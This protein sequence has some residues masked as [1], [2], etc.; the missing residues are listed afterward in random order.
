MT[1]SL[2]A[3]F[4]MLYA[5]SLCTWQGHKLFLWTEAF[6]SAMEMIPSCID[7]LSRWHIWF[8]YTYLLYFRVFRSQQFCSKGTIAASHGHY[9]FSYFLAVVLWLNFCNLTQMR[10]RSSRE[11]CGL[12]GIIA[13]KDLV[14]TIMY[15][16]KKTITKISLW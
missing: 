14:F 12:Q 1:I 10:I 8:H 6:G 2:C 4:A 3:S 11:A 7:S 5:L 15:F 9:S 16:H 13:A